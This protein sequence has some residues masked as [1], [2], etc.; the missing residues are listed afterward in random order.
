MHA[1]VVYIEESASMHLV[2]MLFFSYF[3]LN[4]LHF[5]LF[6]LVSSSYYLRSLVKQLNAT[7]RPDEKISIEVNGPLFFGR[8]EVIQDGSLLSVFLQ[9]GQLKSNICYDPESLTNLEVLY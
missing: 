4:R 8:N 9:K 2:F 6:S 3:Y 1:C 7:G 5:V